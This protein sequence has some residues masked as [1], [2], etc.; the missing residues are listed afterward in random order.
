[1]AWMPQKL[2]KPINQRWLRAAAG[3]RSSKRRRRR[4]LIFTRF[5]LKY[6]SR[7][8]VTLLRKGNGGI[9]ELR[10]AVSQY[11]EQSPLFGFAHYRRRKVVL[12]YV[13]DGT[14]RLL[15]GIFCHVALCVGYR[16]KES[17]I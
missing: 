1:M 3:N 4:K 2:T 12:K 11:G 7:D 9:Q 16:T 14:S 5:L 6:A 10:E 13:P 8:E 15:Q 17:I